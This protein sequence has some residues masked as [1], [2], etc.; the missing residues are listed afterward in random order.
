MWLHFR[1]LHTICACDQR[2]HSVCRG[3]QEQLDKIW[4]FFSHDLLLLPQHYFCYIAMTNLYFI[5]YVNSKIPFN[6]LIHSC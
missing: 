6:S 4:L 2:L 3:C 1:V 5:N